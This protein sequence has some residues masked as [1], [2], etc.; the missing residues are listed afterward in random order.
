LILAGFTVRT[1]DQPATSPGDNGIV[2]DQ[3]PAGGETAPVGT[4]IIIYVG[5]LP[6][7]T[8]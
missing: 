5:R 3:R 6:S 2:L 4:Q 1:I 7:P 8:D